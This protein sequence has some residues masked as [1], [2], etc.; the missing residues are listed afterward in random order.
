MRKLLSVVA[1]GGLLV[2][3]VVLVP[4]VSY[5]QNGP[6]CSGGLCGTPNQSGGG[7][8]CGCGCSILVNMTDL[9]DTYQYADDYDDD[10][11]EDDFDNCPFAS[12]YGQEDSDGDVVGDSCDN[13]QRAV[14]V[15]QLD[16][17]GDGVGDLCD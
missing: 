6:E 9:G 15:E 17:D 4:T 2:A 12:N 1:L 16:I 10:G 8:G 11:W 5:A 3:A 13:C 7:C 14:N